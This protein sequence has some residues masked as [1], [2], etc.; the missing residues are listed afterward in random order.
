ML[1]KTNVNSDNVMCGGNLVPFMF[2]M[3]FKVWQIWGEGYVSKL[4]V[5]VG[6][7]SSVMAGSCIPYES[8]LFSLPHTMSVG[9]MGAD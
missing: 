3:M 4:E 2:H 1:T 8:T 7:D 9:M 5:E 6:R